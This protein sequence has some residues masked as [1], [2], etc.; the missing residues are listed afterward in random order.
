MAARGRGWG[1]EEERGGA[2]ET[3]AAAAESPA[4]GAL[5]AATAPGPTSASPPA[6]DGAGIDS[7]PLA[8]AAAAGEAA[9]EAM[10]RASPQQRRMAAMPSG[11]SAARSTARTPPD[12]PPAASAVFPPVSPALWLHAPS[13]SL[14]QHAAPAARDSPAPSP[15]PAAACARPPSAGCGRLLTPADPSPRQQPDPS[16]APLAQAQPEVDTLSREAAPPAPQQPLLPSILPP[17]PQQPLPARPAP[18]PLPHGASPLPHPSPAFAV[19]VSTP[20]QCMRRC[21]AAKSLSSAANC[22]VAWHRATSGLGCERAAPTRRG[23]AAPTRA[24]APPPDADQYDKALRVRRGQVVL[25]KSA[26]GIVQS[27][28]PPCP[29][30]TCASPHLSNPR[31]WPSKNPRLAPAS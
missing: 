23:S 29:C 26:G 13:D 1:G 22:C 7:D 3:T 2:D 18:A 6:D 10:A 14:P 24:A 15:L 25:D 17:P 4:P 12:P 8:A 20:Q 5:A 28:A 21:T 11:S 30:R 19:E 31:S 27:V 16:V 9:A